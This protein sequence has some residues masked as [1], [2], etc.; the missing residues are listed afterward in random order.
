MNW[1]RGGLVALL[2]STAPLVSADEADEETSQ[3][4][5]G[6]GQVVQQTVQRE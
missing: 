3:S 4:D 2:L 6:F 5:E 1:M